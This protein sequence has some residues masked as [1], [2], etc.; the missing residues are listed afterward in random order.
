MQDRD[1]EFEE[2]QDELAWMLVKLGPMSREDA[3]AIVESD[4]TF[5]PT[6]NL[7][8]ML[9]LHETPYYWAM[10][11]L[12]GREQPPWYKQPGNWPP[13]PELSEQYERDK[14]SGVWRPIQAE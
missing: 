11:H 5:N 8:R 6:T 10:A 4:L 1:T 13:P 12:H 14:A 9:V 2:F 7:A 3:K